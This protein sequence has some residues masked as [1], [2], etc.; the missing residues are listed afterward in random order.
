LAFALLT[1]PHRSLTQCVRS[2]FV[3][4]T[5]LLIANP[6]PTPAARGRITE[7]CRSRYA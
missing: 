6:S 7:R 3:L 4:T 5:Q 2:L 1:R